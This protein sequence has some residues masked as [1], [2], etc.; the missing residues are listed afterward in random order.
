MG[1]IE[2]SGQM[3]YLL[4][5]ID[6]SGLLASIEP[7]KD[8]IK[9]VKKNLKTNL[10]NLNSL[11]PLRAKKVLEVD[12]PVVAE[13]RKKDPTLIKHVDSKLNYVTTALTDSLQ[14]HITYITQDILERQHELENYL[15]AIGQHISH[16]GESNEILRARRALCDGCGQVI[17]WLFGLTTDSELKDTNE[18]LER[19]AKLGEDTRKMVNLHTTILNSSTIHMKK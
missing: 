14:Q 15:L 4:Y 10:N 7:I 5:E 16:E 12:P 6:I 8:S 3:Y 1:G 2:H 19:L 18:A 11:K 13:E 9:K 17:N